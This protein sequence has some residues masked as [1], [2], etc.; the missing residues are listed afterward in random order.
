MSQ[1]QEDVEAS[2]ANSREHPEQQAKASEPPADQQDSRG[3]DDS[4]MRALAD[5]D[6][7]RKRFV[8]EVARERDLERRA[9]AKQ[10]IAVID[11]LERALEYA[12]GDCPGFVEG[13]RVVRDQALEVMNRLGFARFDDIGKEFDPARHEAIAT[14]IGEIPKGRI[15]GVVRAGYGSGDNL[16]RPAGVLVSRGPDG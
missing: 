3:A 1:R 14:A 7:L 15:M 4:L 2:A 13:V 5:L 16:L 8:R 10:W 12:K 6:N 11:N 9:V